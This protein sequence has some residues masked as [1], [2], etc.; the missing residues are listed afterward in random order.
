MSRYTEQELKYFDNPYKIAVIAT[1]DDD[2]D[3]HMFNASTLMNKGDD[4]MMF[5]EFIRGVSKKYIHERPKCGFLIMSADR[6]FWTGSMTFTHSVLEGEDYVYMN[7]Y[8]LF[9]FNTYFGVC[10]VHYAD[11]HDISKMRALNMPGVISNAVKVMA[12]K[13]FFAGDKSKQVMRPWTQEFMNGL[14][15]LE[16]LAFMGED[17]FPKIVPIIQGQ[18]ASSSR[19]FFT[20]APYSDMFEGLKDGVR[21]A[22]Y[23]FSLNTFPLDCSHF[24]IFTPYRQ[25][26]NVCAPAKT[27]F[28]ESVR[29]GQA[30]PSGEPC[31]RS[32][33][34][35]AHSVTAI[36]NQQI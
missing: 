19:I 12:M 35:K 33:R 34:Y 20:K 36:I 31:P 14:I 30:L 27:F 9:R 7:Q 5:G 29:L 1:T 8:Q 2:G 24:G 3:L 22:I 25:R 13:P 10:E 15:T 32:F 6:H 11:L 21:C 4:E 18:S 16:Y 17:G 26:F 23:G 28:I